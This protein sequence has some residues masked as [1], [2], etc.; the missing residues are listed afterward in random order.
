MAAT[1]YCQKCKTPVRLDGSLEELN[2]AAFKLLTGTA[3][4]HVISVV[5]FAVSPLYSSYISRPSYQDE[6][7][8][9]S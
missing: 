9:Q 2:P 6:F 8:Y 7:T 4:Q 5:K 1:M 3:L